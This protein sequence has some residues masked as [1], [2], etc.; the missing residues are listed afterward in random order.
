MNGVTPEQAVGHLIEI[1]AG[2]SGSVLFA[3]GVSNEGFVGDSECFVSRDKE[4]HDVP[5][6]IV[7][8]FIKHSNASGVLLTSRVNGDVAQ[9]SSDLSRFT[10]S[11]LEDAR[12]AG[13]DLVD[14]YLVTDGGLISMREA[15]NLWN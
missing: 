2:V 12:R 1:L 4:V 9:P 6:E 11:F 8:D 10:R 15:T 5:T 7:L 14:H 3:T 13:V